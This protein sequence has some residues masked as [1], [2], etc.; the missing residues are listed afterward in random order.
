MEALFLVLL[1]LCTAVS[2]F[3]IQLGTAL[4]SAVDLLKKEWEEEKAM[5]QKSLRE[6]DDERYKLEQDVRNLAARGALPDDE[7]KDTKWNVDIFPSYETKLV[8]IIALRVVTS[9]GLKEA[10]EEVEY[11]IADR[12]Q[13]FSA[14]L[15]TNQLLAVIKKCG[16]RQ[17][18]NPTIK[19]W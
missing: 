9:L 5:Y 11:R 8:C 1:A 17:G 4:E 3:S 19:P 14:P 13:L 2:N 7:F 12:V 10:K 18:W 6:L 16:D 15:T